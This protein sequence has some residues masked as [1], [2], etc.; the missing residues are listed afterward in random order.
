MA[1]IEDIAI[2]VLI[3]IITLSMFALTYVGVN[4]MIKSW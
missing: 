1:P 4:F 2:G 3:A